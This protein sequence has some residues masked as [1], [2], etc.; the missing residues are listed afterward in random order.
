MNRPLDESLLSKDAQFP[1]ISIPPQ[2]HDGKS[3]KRLTGLGLGI[4]L[5]FESQE[6]EDILGSGKNEKIEDVLGK[7]VENMIC[8]CLI[9]L[10]IWYA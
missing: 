3:V 9:R 1:R 8:E 4:R 5:D 7:S 2:F 6:S 10:C